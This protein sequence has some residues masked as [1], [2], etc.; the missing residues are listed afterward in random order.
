MRVGWLL[1]LD[2]MARHEQQHQLYELTAAS[3]SSATE[4]TTMPPDELEEVHAVDARLHKR[5]LRK[6]DCLLLPF[7][8]LLFLFNALD[9][10]NV[11]ILWT[12]RERNMG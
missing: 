11:R 8:A 9:K 4:H 7:L 2:N 3:T 10:S 6:L 5:T 1:A 12:E